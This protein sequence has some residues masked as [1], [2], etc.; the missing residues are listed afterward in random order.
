MIE[1][2]KQLM[3]LNDIN[4][5]ELCK[6]FGLTEVQMSKY[7]HKRQKI[8]VKLACQVAVFFNVSLDWLLQDEKEQVLH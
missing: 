7:M 6:N 2:L 4:Q 5:I 3:E 8:S 1:R